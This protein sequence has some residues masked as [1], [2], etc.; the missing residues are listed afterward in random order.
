M[1]ATLTLNIVLWTLLGTIAHYTLSQRII[2]AL[3]L[4]LFLMPGIICVCLIVNKG[5]APQLA[6]SKGRKHTVER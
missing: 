6:G 5:G 3:V 4:F 2:V 1:R